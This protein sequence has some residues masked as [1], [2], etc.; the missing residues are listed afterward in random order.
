MCAC[1][2][3]V[4]INPSVWLDEVSKHADKFLCWYCSNNYDC[5]LCLIQLY[6]QCVIMF[7]L[8]AYLYVFLFTSIKKTFSKDVEGCR[9]GHAKNYRN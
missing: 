3:H 2:E 1:Y 4:P 7:Y 5:T 9:D 6:L 8:L